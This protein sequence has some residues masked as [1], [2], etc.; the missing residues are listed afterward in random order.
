MNSVALFTANFNSWRLNLVFRSDDCRA[1]D[2]DTDDTATTTTIAPD[3][4]A[5][6]LPSEGSNKLF[7]FQKIIDKF[8]PSDHL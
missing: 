2:D 4:D 6:Y 8:D 5:L 7:G 3:D 1:A